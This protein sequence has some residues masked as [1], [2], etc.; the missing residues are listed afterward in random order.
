VPA[1]SGQQLVRVVGSQN[2]ALPELGGGRIAA[3]GNGKPIDVSPVVA[4]L[5]QRFP[6]PHFRGLLGGSA[7]DPDSLVLHN[8][9]RSSSGSLVM[10]Q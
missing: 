9:S 8:A 1:D 5:G 6:A 7:V 3:F 10:M 2:V 4:H